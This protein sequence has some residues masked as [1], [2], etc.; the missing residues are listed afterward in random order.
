ME[1]RLQKVMA[2]AGVGSRRKCEELI[3]AGKVT[4]NGKLVDRLG[5]RA[6]PEKDEIRVNSK[7]ITLPDRMYYILLNKPVGYTS[8]RFDPY[9]KKTVMELVADVSANLHTVGRLDV[10]TEGLIILTNDGDLTFKLTHPSHEVRKTYVATVRGAVE[11]NELQQLREGVQLEDGMTA[12]AEVKLLNT[13]PDGRRSVVE[14]TIH[15]GK[16]RQVRRMLNAV[17]HRVEH[18]AR[19]KI[20]DIKI[21]NLPS[22]AWRH[23]TDAEIKRLKGK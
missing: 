11:E 9:A 7:L 6:D 13:S 14:I 10:D 21:G 12:P 15:E 3:T 8:T 22:G 5:S 16:K 19:T 4:I 23:L 2:M 17:G 1:E 20:A 18:L